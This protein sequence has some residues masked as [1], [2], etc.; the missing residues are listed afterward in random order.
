MLQCPRKLGPV[1]KKMKLKNSIVEFVKQPS[2]GV[3]EI[4][5]GAINSGCCCLDRPFLCRRVCR[6]WAAV[7]LGCYRFV[8]VAVQRNALGHEGLDL[9]QEGPVVFVAAPCTCGALCS[10]CAGGTVFWLP[11]IES[12]QSSY[13]H[14]TSLITGESLIMSQSPYLPLHHDTNCA[15]IATCSCMNIHTCTLTTEPWWSLSSGDAAVP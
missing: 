9:N 2:T 14:Q 1:K 4:I 8:A 13:M 6:R 11:S 7:L 12:S 5:L 15:A 3:D 10:A